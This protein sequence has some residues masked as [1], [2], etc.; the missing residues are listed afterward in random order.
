MV[1]INGKYLGWAIVHFCFMSSLI[2][3]KGKIHDVGFA[4][5][6][7]LISAFFI[8]RFTENMAKVFK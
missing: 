4:I 8:W 6:M 7:L 5:T 1:K 2:F 3:Y